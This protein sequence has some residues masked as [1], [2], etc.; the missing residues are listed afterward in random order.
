LAVGVEDSHLGSSDLAIGTR[1]SRGRRS[2]NEWWARN[3]R[4]S[5]LNRSNTLCQIL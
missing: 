2:R 3:L 5:L 1:A 4:F